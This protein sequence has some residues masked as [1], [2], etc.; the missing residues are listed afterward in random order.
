MEFSPE[1]ESV[2]SSSSLQTAPVYVELYDHLVVKFVP[3]HW[4]NK[5]DIFAA[6]K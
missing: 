5:C 3:L 4:G 6:K 2:E 1:P